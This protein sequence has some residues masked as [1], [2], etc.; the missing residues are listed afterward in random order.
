[1]AEDIK[2]ITGTMVKDYMF[3]PTIFYHKHI[4]RIYEPETEMMRSGREAFDDIE[5]KSRAWRTLLG[6]RRIK[7]DKTLY[8]VYVY[9]GKY[10]CSGIVDVVYWI[11]RKCNVL[12]IK[13]SE[14]RKP[15]ISHIYQ[16]AI[17][18][19]MVEE[20]FS[21]TVSNIEIYYTLSDIH[22]RKIF[23]SGVRRYAV[24]ILRRIS[25]IL[26]GN[27]VP[28]PKLSRR[29]HTCWYRSICYP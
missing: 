28:Q 1:M 18:A 17:Y 24:S 29:C 20:T 27:E 11:R 2:L 7:P 14:L 5:Y 22:F 3:C 25:H 16:A 23:S 15:D 9:S 10:D 12:E 4:A 8:S 26:L 21:T 6:K 19:L 13:E